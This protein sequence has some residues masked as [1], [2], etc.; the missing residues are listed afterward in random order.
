MHNWYTVCDVTVS[1]SSGP[2]SRRPRRASRVIAVLAVAAAAIAPLATGS[3]AR[4][5]PGSVTPPPGSVA[6]RQDLSAAVRSIDHGRGIVTLEGTGPVGGSIGISGDG[7]EPTRTE[8]DPTGSWSVPVRVRRGDRLLHVESMVT[9]ASID[10]PV[11]LLLL[12]PP[13][14][15]AT[16]DGIE[17]TITL[18]GSGREHAHIVLKDDGETVGAVDADADG[19]WTFV[20]RDLSFGPHHVEAFQYFDGT[21]NGGVDEVYTVSGAPT[22]TTATASR[23]SGRVA[24]AGRAP[25]DT[26]L[27]FDD[28]DGPVLGDD[29]RPVSVQVGPGTAW[30]VDLPIPAASRFY[31]VRVTTHQGETAVGS[32]DARITVPLELTGTVEAL[33]DGSV[34]LSGTG[35][36]GGEVTLADDAGATVTNADGEPITT[37]TGRRWELIVPRDALPDQTVIARQRVAGTAQGSV[38]LTLPA[39]PIVPAPGPDPDGGPGVSTGPDTTTPRPATDR[40]TPDRVRV[41]AATGADPTIPL[42]VAGALLAAGAGALGVL[43]CSRRLRARRG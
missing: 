16:V 34:R 4:A 40:T 9:G 3:V 19:G 38:R 14:L 30:S 12:L 20:L 1:F 24:L 13:D 22:V 29:G 37:I 27:G 7:V 36:V 33:P 6:A 41:L 31:R 35:E 42:G 39:L 8:A 11:T 26:R 43:R 5:D 18:I 2:S 28:A 17:R 21:Q 25:A 32:A 15:F 23:E 10:L